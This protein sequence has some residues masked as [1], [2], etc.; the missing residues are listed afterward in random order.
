M[1]GIGAGR[2]RLIEVSGDFWSRETL[3]GVWKRTKE[4]IV[5]CLKRLS[6]H[7]VLSAA[8]L[9]SANSLIPLF[10]LHHRWSGRPGYAFNR[11]FRWFLLANADG[12]Y[13][14]SAVTTLNEDVR[15]IQEAGSFDDAL[16]SV[17]KRLRVSDR[18]EPAEF[19][20]RYDRA[21][22]R[23]LRLMVYLL[24][25]QRGAVDWVDGTRIGYDKT[26][27]RV[28]TGYEP[29]WHHIYPRSVLRRAGVKTDDIHALANITVLNANTNEKRLRSKEPWRYIREFGIKRDSLRCHAVPEGFCGCEESDKGLRE[30]WSIERYGDF[31]LARAEVL[32]NEATAFL[33]DLGNKK[34]SGR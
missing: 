26:G 31:L 32:A 9:P 10:V 1:T 7:G 33:R 12:R 6:E 19:L 15:A 28:T 24:M 18:I 13:S 34:S 27:S 4:A 2:A 17:E 14:G 5:D 16:A 22:N 20:E 21:G 29:E 23:F 30:G 3:P 11:A 25:F 8:V